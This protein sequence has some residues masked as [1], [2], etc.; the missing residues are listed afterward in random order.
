MILRR[1]AD[2]IREQN[3]F[4][5]IIEILIVVI[6]V[7]IGLQVQQWADEQARLNQETTYMQRLHNEV[8]DLR[9]ARQS[10]LQTRAIWHDN[11]ATA[12][13]VIFGEENRAL[14]DDEC[15]GVNYNY[16]V[17]N[18]TADI[19]SLL[20]LQSS[21]RISIIQ[22]EAVSKALQS[23]LLTRARAGDSQAQISKLTK[24]IGPAYPQ[25]I[26]VISPTID[27]AGGVQP[28]TFEC[29][30]EGM[31]ADEAF[32]QDLELAQIHFVFHMNDNTRVSDSLEALHQ[33]LDG[34]LS[35]SHEESKP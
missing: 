31:R 22:N 14:T 20:E 17:S 33:V 29:D 4:T 10:V 25:L 13:P 34:V 3:W 23:F 28:G 16:L 15:R 5:V 2:A 11:M 8:I 12:L 1:I 27:T 19:G 6:G 24:P 32:K 18:P 7:F 35:Y 26:K 9:T 21:G 30:I